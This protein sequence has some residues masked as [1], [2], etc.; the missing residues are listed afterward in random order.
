MQIPGKRTVGMSL[1]FERGSPVEVPDAI[2]RRLPSLRV[3]SFSGSA[4][5]CQGFVR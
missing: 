2:L 5:A 1:N 4:W 3:P